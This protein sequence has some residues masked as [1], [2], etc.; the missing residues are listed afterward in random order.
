MPFFSVLQPG[1]V[2]MQSGVV[3]A[4]PILLPEIGPPIRS[5]SRLIPR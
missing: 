5:S 1:V 2:Q 4:W 3:Q